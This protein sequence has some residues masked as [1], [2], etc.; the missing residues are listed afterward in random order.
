MAI[1]F[2]AANVT[3]LLTTI[4]QVA[5][6]DL[7]VGHRALGYVETLQ[8]NRYASLGIGLHN[9]GVAFRDTYNLRLQGL[10]ANRRNNTK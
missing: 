7:L 10:S 2:S 5:P 9:D 1:N 8:S 6:A 4:L 3:T